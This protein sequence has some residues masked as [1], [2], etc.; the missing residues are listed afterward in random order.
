[1]ADSAMDERALLRHLEGLRERVAELE[2]EARQRAV[3][4]EHMA[5]VEHALTERVKEL[6]CLYGISR[7]VDH[8]G[9]SLDRLLQGTVDLLPASWQYPEVTCARITFE[10]RQYATANFKTSRWKQVARID[11]GGKQAGTVEVYYLRKRPACDEG[12][13]LKEERLLIDAVAER[14]GRATERMRAQQQ[15]EVERA[16]LRNMNIAL[17]EVLSRVQ[18]EKM[19]VGRA[20]QANVDKIIVPILDALEAEGSAERRGYISLLRRNLE[21][22]A[23]PFAQTLSKTFMSL[24]PM[25]V[26]VCD[27]LRRGLSTKEIARLRRVSAA[28]VARHREHIRHKLGL[29]NTDVNLATY[30][31]TFMSEGAGD[32]EEHVL[33]QPVESPLRRYGAASGRG[34]DR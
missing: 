19:E 31:H 5:T 16:A 24:T 12:P 3:E 22:I 9:G 28:T 2:A 32:T 23:G 26:R 21:E 14:M 11:V 4:A 10:Q 25:E 34:Q 18:Q 15:L 7:T 6:N 13:F 8:C 30:L 17:R 27:M 29:T 20:V 1:M 33:T